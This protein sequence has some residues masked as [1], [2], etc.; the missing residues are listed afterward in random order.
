MVS[1]SIGRLRTS[2]PGRC[3]S[4][5]AVDVVDEPADAVRVALDLGERD[6]R[7]VDEAVAQRLDAT[8]TTPRERAAQL[9]R[10]VVGRR[11]A[12]ARPG[13]AA[14]GQPVDGLRPRRAI[15][16]PPPSPVARVSSSPAPS[17]RGDLGQPLERP[18]EVE[19]D[20]QREGSASPPATMPASTS[21]PLIRSWITAGSATAP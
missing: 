19:R 4:A 12:R 14:R 3:A 5:S 15:S 6:V 2:R 8:R 13:G 18:R 17:L 21:R 1:R 10:H 16:R 9:V 20:E 11:A 7:V